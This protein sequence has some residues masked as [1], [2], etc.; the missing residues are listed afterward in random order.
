M[1]IYNVE[2]F[3]REEV[4]QKISEDEDSDEDYISEEE[5]LFQHGIDP[6][7][8]KWVHH[9]I[10]CFVRMSCIFES[11]VVYFMMKS[12]QLNVGALVVLQEM[13]YCCCLYH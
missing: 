9:R 2:R 13:F 11:C 3:S 4:L 12:H 5:E 6:E 8:D 1:A 7:I 10:I